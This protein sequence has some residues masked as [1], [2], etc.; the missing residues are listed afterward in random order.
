[1]AGDVIG[2]PL[3]TGEQH[4]VKIPPGLRVGDVFEIDLPGKGAASPKHKPARGRAA[5]VTTPQSLRKNLGKASVAKRSGGPPNEWVGPRVSPWRLPF[6]WCRPRPIAR[7]DTHRSDGVCLSAVA[8]VVSVWRRGGRLVALWFAGGWWRCGSFAVWP[9]SERNGR[10][11]TRRSRVFDPS[12]PTF[13]RCLAL[14]PT[15]RPGRRGGLAQGRPHRHAD[16][17]AGIQGR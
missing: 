15:R 10:G 16:G 5:S 8:V 4:F 14:R 2:I 7:P 3:P 12:G 9:V 13:R 11:R 17:S 1:M 6:V